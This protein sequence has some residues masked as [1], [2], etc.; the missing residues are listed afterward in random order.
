LALVILAGGHGL[1]AMKHHFINKD[2]T[3]IRMFGKT[4]RK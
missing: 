1:A 2:S 4:K 3:L